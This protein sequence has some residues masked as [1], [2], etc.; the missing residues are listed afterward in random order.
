MYSGSQVEQNSPSYRNTKAMTFKI[1][2]IMSMVLPIRLS[3]EQTTIFNGI[4]EENLYL[5]SNRESIPFFLR[6]NCCRYTV[7]SLQRLWVSHPTDKIFHARKK[8]R[9]ENQL[10]LTHRPTDHLSGGQIVWGKSKQIS[11]ILT[12]YLYSYP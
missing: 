7:K 9:K 10:N 2:Y 12:T 1:S 5:F 6:G 8:A 3:T 11:D 4:A